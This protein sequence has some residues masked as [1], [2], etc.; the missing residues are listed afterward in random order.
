MARTIAPV[1]M[2]I[3]RWVVRMPQDG[4][5]AWVEDTRTEG[6]AKRDMEQRG[7]EGSRRKENDRGVVVAAMVATVA[8]VAVGGAKPLIGLG[9]DLLLTAERRGTVTRLGQAHNDNAG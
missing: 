9:T 5:Q 1:L 7:R 3:G 2:N 4:R 6:V 8:G